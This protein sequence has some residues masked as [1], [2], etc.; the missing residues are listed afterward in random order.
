[1]DRFSIVND[2]LLKAQ[3]DNNVES[4]MHTFAEFVLH[5]EYIP[6]SDLVLGDS[7]PKRSS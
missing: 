3:S 1:M 6:C 2:A 4:P 7:L 5:T